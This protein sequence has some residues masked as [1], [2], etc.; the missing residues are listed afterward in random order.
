[1][2]SFFYGYGCNYAVTIDDVHVGKEI[3]A[4]IVDV[5]SNM[6]FAFESFEGARRVDHKIQ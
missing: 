4:S 5:A 6:K 1:V 2:I 3:H